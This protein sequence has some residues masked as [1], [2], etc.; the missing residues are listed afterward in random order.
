VC[1][2]GR[3]AAWASVGQKQS[4]NDE[5]RKYGNSK[6]DYAS[7]EKRDIQAKGTCLDTT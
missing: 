4:M 6:E 3:L 5:S 1:N 7:A 2:S